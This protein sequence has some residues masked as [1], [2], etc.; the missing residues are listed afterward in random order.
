M[1]NRRCNSFIFIENLHLK[2]QE[3]T[4]TR[5]HWFLGTKPALGTPSTFLQGFIP[6]SSCSFWTKNSWNN[7]LVLSIRK[8]LLHQPCRECSWRAETWLN[9]HFPAASLCV[10]PPLC[11]SLSSF[12]FSPKLPLYPSVSFW[13]LMCL[14]I[15]SFQWL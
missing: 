4:E 8:V 6:P 13:S 7:P 10:L 11:I 3:I 2:K 1:E 9:W 5:S 12:A 15:F 14:G